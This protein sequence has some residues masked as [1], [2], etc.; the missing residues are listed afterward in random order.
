MLV[1]SVFTSLVK[2]TTSQ[3]IKHGHYPHILYLRYIQVYKFTRTFHFAVRLHTITQK[4][5]DT[6]EY[7]K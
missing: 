2:E 5:L 1:V 7:N 4:S 6:Y 3:M